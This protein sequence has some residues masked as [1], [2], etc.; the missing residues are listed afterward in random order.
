M[1]RR[2]FVASLLLVLT[3]APGSRAFAQEA[4][5]SLR[6]D[7]GA[8]LAN[9][10]ATPAVAPGEQFQNFYRPVAEPNRKRSSSL[11]AGLYASTAVMQ[12][13]DVHSTLSALGTG[14]VEGNPLMAGVTR[15]KGAFIAMKAGVA[16]SAIFAA[17]GVAKHNKVAAIA[18]LVAINSAYALVARHNYQVARA[19]R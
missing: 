15:N 12:A 7:L 3:L 1:S 5:G 17:K 16:V 10:E 14:A 6:L 13:L 18:T 9:A 11:L 2:F 4:A 8:T 19:G